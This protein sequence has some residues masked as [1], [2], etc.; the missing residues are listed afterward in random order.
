[1]TNGPPSSSVG[2]FSSPQPCSQVSARGLALRHDTRPTRLQDVHTPTATPRN[3]L[4]GMILMLPTSMLCL[5]AIGGAPATPNPPPLPCQRC[6]KPLLLVPTPVLHEI[7]QSL[8]RRPPVLFLGHCQYTGQGLLFPPSGE[9][10]AAHGHAEAGCHPVRRAAGVGLGDAADGQ[11]G[12]SNVILQI[13][14]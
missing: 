8:S 6:Q 1:M 10:G 5:L 2:H 11:D 4:P 3:G 9:F 12:S 13:R 7:V 14:K